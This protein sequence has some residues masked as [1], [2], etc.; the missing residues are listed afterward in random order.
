MSTTYVNFDIEVEHLAD[1]TY[2]LRIQSQA[3]ELRLRI[4]FPYNEE[5]LERQL[6]LIE[7]ALLSTQSLRR[8][9]AS[10]HEATV[11]ELGR[12]LF[13]ALFPGE[14]RG[15][16]YECRRTAAQNGA[17]VRVRLRLLSPE[18]TTV[19]WE[20]L[21]DDT[22]GE[23]LC[24]SRDTPFVRMLSVPKPLTPLRIAPPLRIL[25]FACSPAGLPPL[26]VNL[27]RSRLEQ[28]LSRLQARG[29]VHLEWLENPTWRDLQRTMRAG[30]W[31]VFHFVGH[32]AFDSDREEGTI[33][34]LDDNGAPR[35]LTASQLALL[36][37]NHGFL[38]LAVINACESAQSSRRD[39]FASI[40]ASLLRSGLPAVIAM[41]QEITDR[42][43]IEFTTTFY[44]AIADGMPLDTAMSEARV[45]VCVAYND[46]VEWGTPVL[47][48]HAPDGVIFDLQKGAATENAPPAAAARAIDAP[49]AKPPPSTPPLASAPG[50][51]A[52]PRT[53]ALFDWVM[54]P[55]GAFWMG[56]DLG[57]DAH[58]AADEQ[59]QHRV[60][61]PAFRI[62]RTPVTN[63]QYQAYVQA[64]GAPPPGHWREGAI[65]AGKEN[66]PVVQVSWREAVAF[67]AWA[68]V[69]LPS[70]AQWEKAARGTDGRI[71]PW[72][73][74]PPDARRANFDRTV[75]EPTPVDAY[76]SGAS[77]FG[78]LD[79]AGNVLEW[80]RSLWGSNVAAPDEPYP[81][82]DISLDE[83]IS[84]PD[85]VLRVLRGGAFNLAAVCLRCAFRSTS[86]AHR[87]NPAIGF[88]VVTLPNQGEPS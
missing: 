59:P 24:L 63:R 2:A 67:C 52:T 65:P 3:G 29:L 5:Q 33:L 17:G 78:V 18:L 13:N 53:A 21:Y 87:R 15:L 19:P 27:E 8:R 32:G 26:D 81:A 4:T 45:S 57:Q 74:E 71:Y 31:H 36:L 61:L 46:C 54:I 6:L 47:Y 69:A 40:A 86:V 12:T 22:Y 82:V 55:A 48:L 62:A 83:A 77:P 66:H 28:A 23:Y 43:S 1:L 75:G 70:E 85:R 51:A 34:L 11:Q 9:A 68:G 42:A 64:T 50:P 7:N 80:T 88:R 76:P 20:F 16:Y 44:E 49:V 84:A 79:M 56:S 38:R 41:Q 58:A 10:P 73:A 72:G 35:P 14:A 39:M 37:A 25:G 30:P 60:E